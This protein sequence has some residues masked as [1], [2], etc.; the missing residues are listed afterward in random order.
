MAFMLPALA[1]A[2]GGLLFRKKGGV[3][4]QV[5]HPLLQS[6]PDMTKQIILKSMIDSPQ[7][8]KH[9]GLVNELALLKSLKKKKGGVV[10][11]KKGGKV[12]SKSK[13]KKH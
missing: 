13:V 9:G 10:H 4:S 5:P 7:N 3:I 11:K 8:L 6:K 12:K 1:S 2:L